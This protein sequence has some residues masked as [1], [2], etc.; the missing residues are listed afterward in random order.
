[1]RVNKV[2]H[3][4]SHTPCVYKEWGLV[5]YVKSKLLYPLL[6]VSYYH[7]LS[8]TLDYQENNMNFLVDWTHVM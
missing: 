6:T 5:S 2:S 3:G 4:A 8:D 1:M 7:L